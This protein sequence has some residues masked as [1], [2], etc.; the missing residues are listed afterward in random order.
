MRPEETFVS[1]PIRSLQQMLRVIAIQDPAYIAVVPDGIYGPQTVQA[2]SVFQRR[3]GIPVTGVTDQ[4]T[5]EQVVRI[6]EPA[7]I[8]QQPPHP[9]SITLEPGQVIRRGETHPH[10]YLA[11]AMLQMLFIHYQSVSQSSVSGV[12]DDATAQALESFQYLTGLPVTGH[13]DRHT[14]KH[15]VLHYPLAADLHLRHSGTD[16]KV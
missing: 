3:H 15:L 8:Q 5:W 4:A 1:Q 14:W 2:V 9:L 12:L 6:Y 7:V 10:L 11:Q 16:R 13:L